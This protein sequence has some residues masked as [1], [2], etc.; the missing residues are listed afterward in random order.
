MILIFNAVIVFLTLTYVIKRVR[1][2][3]EAHR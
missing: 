1:R 2:E 3:A